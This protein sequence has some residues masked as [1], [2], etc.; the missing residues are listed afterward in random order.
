MSDEDGEVNMCMIVI[1]YCSTCAGMKVY[2]SVCQECGIQV[3]RSQAI[4]NTR[5]IICFGFGMICLASCPCVPTSSH[6][7]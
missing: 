6:R 5:I 3:I 4:P 1:G 2:R 7:C